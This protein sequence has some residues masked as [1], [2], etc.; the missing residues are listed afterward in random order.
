M[1]TLLFTL[2]VLLMIFLPVV[3]GALARRRLQTPWLLFMVGTLTF[4]GSQVVHLPL[5]D[6]L[7]RLNVLPKTGMIDATIPVLQTALV[8]GLTAGLCEETARVVGLLLLKRYRKV[9]DSI[10]LGIGHGGVE[11]MIF[12]GVMVAATMSSLLPLMEQDLSQLGLLPEQLTYLTAQ[13]DGLNN[14]PFWAAFAPLIERLLAMTLHVILSV[15]VMEAFRRRTVLFYVLAVV[16]HLLVDAG[17]VYAVNLGL[18]HTTILL[19]FSAMLLPGLAWLAWVWRKEARGAVGDHQPF[20]AE[21]AIFL[22]AVRKE[23]VQQ[24]R[25]RR[26]LVV[27]AVFILFGL[28]SPLV[29]KMI[30]D[31]LKNVAGAEQFASLVPTPTSADAMAQYIKNL[32]QFGFILAVVLG[33]NAVAGEKESGTAAM[34]LSKP[35]PRWAFLMSKFTAQEL[36]YLSAFAVAGLG[37]YYYTIILF[38]AF[39]VS[40]FVL[41]NLL[42]M[43]WLTTFVGAALLGSVVGNSIA[44]AA[45]VGIGISAVFLLAGNIPQYGM[46]AP[47][48][49]V[50]WA[51]TLGGSA[52]GSAANAGALAAAVVLTTLCL[53]WALAIFERQEI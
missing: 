48:G 36:L 13:I 40:A 4:I 46:L 47:G 17:A 53:L 26:F 43:V 32:T 39:D 42:L 20:G 28:T 21:F 12:G 10:M 27:M 9:E 6:L 35:M 5:N 41:I 18:E 37:A 50:A 33:M 3:F 45:G 19:I 7:V 29:A 31:I 24:W 8:L 11:A 2:S 22:S 16:Y 38:G 14:A 23:W 52:P 44:S 1:L 49:L 34:I 15:M 25:T 30:P 51:S